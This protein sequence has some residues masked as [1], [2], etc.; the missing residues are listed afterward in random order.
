MQQK[1]QKKKK[2]IKHKNFH[3][4]NINI[5]QPLDGDIIMIFFVKNDYPLVIQQFAMAAMSH[6]YS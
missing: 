1:K 2:K 3:K 4:N 5:Y 6:I